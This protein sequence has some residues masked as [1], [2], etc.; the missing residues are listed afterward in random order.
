MYDGEL[1]ELYA[2]KSDLT[3]VAQQIL[4]DEIKKRGLDKPREPEK[5]MIPPVSA[6]APQGLGNGDLPAAEEAGEAS[7]SPVEYTWKTPLCDCDDREEAWQ[8]QLALKD[9]GIDSWIDRS[10]YYVAPESGNFRI[11]VAADQLEKAQEIISK[12]IPKEIVE[13]S[14]MDIQD[15]EPP[16]CPSCGTADPVLES[17]DPVNSW[18][19]ESCGRQWTE[20]AQV[21]EGPTKP[22]S[23]QTVREEENPFA[24]GPLT[25]L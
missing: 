5:R 17:A 21:E 14:R 12:P 3:E 4:T 13:Q 9:A 20:Q 16:V 1:E 24:S 25:M 15:Y 8:I 23:T 2:D 19:C 6:D 7:E 18:R 10:G 22:Q 11:V